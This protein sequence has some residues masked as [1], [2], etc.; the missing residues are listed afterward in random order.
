MATVSSPNPYRA[1]GN[2]YARQTW[3]AVHRH[4][5]SAFETTRTFLAAHPA[6]VQGVYYCLFGMWPVVHIDSF[7]AVTGLKT[8]LWLVQTLGLIIVLIGSVLCLAEYRRQQSPEVLLIA[9]GSATVLAGIDLFFALAGRIS[10]VYL[11]DAA[12]ELAIFFLWL[13]GWYLQTVVNNRATAAGAAPVS[14]QAAVAANE[15]IYPGRPQ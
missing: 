2:D 10:L 4:G 15:Q 1:G 11:V 14:G 9:L 13:Y 7:I 12:V 3:N 5:A 8:D 6:L